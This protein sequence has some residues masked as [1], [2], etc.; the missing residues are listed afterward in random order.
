MLVGQWYICPVFSKA[1]NALTK[2]WRRK[3]FWVVKRIDEEDGDI[4]DTAYLNKFGEALC[5]RWFSELP[6][7]YKFKSQAKAEEALALWHLREAAGAT[8]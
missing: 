2:R 5:V 3:Q 6:E 4:G 1:R 7:D 8:Q